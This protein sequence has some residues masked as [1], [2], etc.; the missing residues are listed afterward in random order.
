MTTKHQKTIT[1]SNWLVTCSI[2]LLCLG[3]IPV[4]RIGYDAGESHTLK[5]MCRGLRTITSD[6][7]P[8]PSQVEEIINNLEKNCYQ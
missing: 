1:K 3:Y 4:F 7:E 5:Y 2:I 8:L 6:N